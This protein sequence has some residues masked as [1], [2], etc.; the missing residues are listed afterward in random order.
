MDALLFHWPFTCIHS[1]KCEPEVTLAISIETV[2]S[3]TVQN[4]FH[5]PI[6]LHSLLHSSPSPPLPLFT[7]FG[8]ILWLAIY[9]TLPWSTSILDPIPRMKLTEIL[10]I[11]FF[12]QPLAPNKRATSLAKKEMKTH[13]RGYLPNCSC[14][15]D[16]SWPERNQ[17]VGW[18]P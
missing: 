5:W 16:T 8:F 11:Y 2:I 7:L 18:S 4:T 14:P 6:G 9:L 3:G 15:T 1:L 13:L 12:Y 17:E 10:R